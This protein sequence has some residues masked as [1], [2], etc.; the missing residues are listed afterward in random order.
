MGL[1]DQR[2]PSGL[3]PGEPP[4]PTY[5]EPYPVRAG[6]VLAGFGAAAGWLGL[7]ALLGA[8]LR[9]RLWWTVVAGGV[10][11]L[12]SLALARSGD[13]GVAVGVALATG[14]GWSLVGGLVALHWWVGGDWPLW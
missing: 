4:R 6:A 11:W 12:A 1:P 10:A 14:A 5:R 8:D 7:F 13:R 9:G 3:F 2:T